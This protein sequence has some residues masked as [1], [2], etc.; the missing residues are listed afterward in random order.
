M[1]LLVRIRG[2]RTRRRDRKAEELLAL[3]ALS[4]EDT[5]DAE[6]VQKRVLDDWWK[7]QLVELGGESPGGHAGE[8]GRPTKH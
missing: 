2:W 1:A 4:S 7:G 6:R 5:A 8:E 3:A